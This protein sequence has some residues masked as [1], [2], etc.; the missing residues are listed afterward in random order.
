MTRQEFLEYLKKENVCRSAVDYVSA[1]KLETLDAIWE[2][3]DRGDWMLWLLTREV[4][5]G[6]EKHKRIVLA[7]CACARLSLKYIK[8]AG[9]RGIAEAAL[10]KAEGWVKGNVKLEDVKS[11]ADVAFDYDVSAAD[12]VYAAVADAASAS[13]AVDA[14]V[15]IRRQCANIIRSYFSKAELS[16][17]IGKTL[18]SD[19]L[20]AS[21]LQYRHRS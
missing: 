18:L 4:E 17:G 19:N 9:R 1:S 2:S 7:A 20:N 21:L 6:S 11:A 16:G 3:C 10:E 12:A 14:D 13:A 15:V 5:Q 8:D